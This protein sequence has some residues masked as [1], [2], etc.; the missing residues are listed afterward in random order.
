MAV[1]LSQLSWG[2]MH[3]WSEQK[4]STL[5]Y[6]NS[7]TSVGPCNIYIEFLINAWRTIVVLDITIG[8]SVG[9]QVANKTLSTKYNY[10]Y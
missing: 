4:N 7:E 5:N 9:V 3:F 10:V 6:L 8:D 1:G 2:D